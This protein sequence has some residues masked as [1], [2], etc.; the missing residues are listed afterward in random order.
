MNAMNMSKHFSF[1]FFLF[2]PLAMPIINGQISQ[3]GAPN[4]AWSVEFYCDYRF[5]PVQNKDDFNWNT[6]DIIK[7]VNLPG[8]AG[9]GTCFDCTEF[10]W[11]RTA[12]NWMK[13]HDLPAFFD[14]LLTI[15]LRDEDRNRLLY[16][17]DSIVMI[18]PNVLKP[19]VSTIVYEIDMSEFCGV[20]VRHI[21][22]YS[23]TD[24]ALH[25]E[26]SSF[27]PLL[28]S[29][30][31]Q[32]QKIDFKPMAW[33][34]VYKAPSFESLFASGDINYIFQTKTRDKSPLIENMTPLTGQADFVRYFEERLEKLDKPF[35]STYNSFQTLD[36][37]YLSQ[38][39]N[40][41][42]SNDNAD[43]DIIESE[44]TT[45]AA[46]SKLE[47]L[48]RLLIMANWFVD[49]KNKKMYFQPV[50][51]APG[52][53]VKDQQGKIQYFIPMFFMQH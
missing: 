32:S 13:D 42:H 12:N 30:D 11:Q 53:S 38:F 22:Y 9:F 27:A 16:R 15:A 40:P 28:K 19:Q 35:Y 21:A 51:Y 5:D 46:R 24:S 20:R 45:V 10:L 26:A 52:Q 31:H 4:M 48:G 36:Q 17:I 29:H 23:P 50:G 8:P 33:F 43:D 34:P 44:K 14:P 39:V 49:E 1:L 41:S 7:R 25:I 37:E 6:L 18:D 3:Q 47:N 2:A